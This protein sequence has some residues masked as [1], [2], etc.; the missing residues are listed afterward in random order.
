MGQLGQL[1]QLRSPCEGGWQGQTHNDWLVVCDCHEFY[2]P[3]NIGFMSSSQL[4]HLYFSEGWP[5][6]QPDDDR[7][8][9]TVV[10]ASCW[11][12]PW[13]TIFWIVFVLLS[14]WMGI[15]FAA[16]YNLWIGRINEKALTTGEL[17][18][19]NFDLVSLEWFGGFYYPNGWPYFTGLSLPPQL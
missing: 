15:P 1:G 4:T 12:L 7:A 3:R 19:W 17:T 11:G 18:T 9:T 13:L 2:I 14:C 6:H 10:F 5:N 16:E 8:F